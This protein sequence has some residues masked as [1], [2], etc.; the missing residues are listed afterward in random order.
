MIRQFTLTATMDEDYGSVGWALPEM[1]SVYNYIG[2][3]KG[4]AHDLFEHLTGFGGTGDEMIA[5]GVIL[6]LRNGL[7]EGCD[8][9]NLGIMECTNLYAYFGHEDEPKRLDE[10]PLDSA[11]EESFRICVRE[12]FD[13]LTTEQ[14][15]VDDDD[16][17]E[18]AQALRGYLTHLRYGYRLAEKTY[19]QLGKITTYGAFC[20]TVDFFE[21]NQHFE[22]GDQVEFSYDTET[23]ELSLEMVEYEKD[24]K[25]E[26]E[27]AL[28]K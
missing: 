12:A 6:W 17:R 23:G 26:L 11:T 7:E 3:G 8:P 2:N 14:T 16:L 13:T 22:E 20:Q 27:R 15:I 1:S 28:N 24:F 10:P 19:G 9:R 18:V 4:I 25:V 21:E 5:H